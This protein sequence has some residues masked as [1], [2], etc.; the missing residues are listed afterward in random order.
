[1]NE[2]QFNRYVKLLGIT[3]TKPSIKSLTKI[4]RAHLSKVPFENI[5]KLYRFKSNNKINIPNID[6]FLDGIEKFHFGGTCYTNNYF[7][8][9]LLVHLGYE[10]KLCGADMKNPDVHIVNIVKI[11]GR[12]FIVDVGYAAPFLE[13]L[14]IDLNKPFALQY[15]DDKY[16]I[17]PKNEVGKSRL[18]LYKNGKLRHGYI[19]KPEPRQIKEFSQIIAD[20][21]SPSATFMNAVLLVRYDNDFSYIIH[22]KQFI[23]MHNG[24]KTIKELHSISELVQIIYDVFKISHEITSI[25]LDGLSFEGNAWG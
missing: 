20:S 12:E 8:N 17:S 3:K 16:I 2:D 22:N 18:E 4:I 19:V 11:K 7:L 13:P 1:M 5:S 23:V 10:V 6:K 9:L 15:G 25:A 14:P 21:F 24:L